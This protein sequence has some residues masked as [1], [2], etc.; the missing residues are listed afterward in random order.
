MNEAQ[1]IVRAAIAA[2]E[3]PTQ[4]RLAKNMGL[5][6]ST[7]SMWVKGKKHPSGPHLLQLMAI[8]AGR[9]GRKAAAVAL[10]FIVGGTAALY[11]APSP[12]ATE[13]HC[14]LCQIL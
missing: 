6:Q 1:K 11:P 4:Y 3:P 12:A 13:V 5:A 8:A 2:C 10:A 9:A 14:I 7:V